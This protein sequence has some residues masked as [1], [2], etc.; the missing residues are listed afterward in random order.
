[1]ESLTFQAGKQNAVDVL[2]G[3]N[4]DEANFGICGPNAGLAGRGGAGMNVGAFK[5]AA[6][7]KFGEMA[8]EYLRLYPAATDEDARRAAQEAEPVPPAAKLAFYASAFQRLLKG[9]AGAAN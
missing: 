9:A 4:K 7:R 5:T 2:T 1:D 6:D 8:G 3:S